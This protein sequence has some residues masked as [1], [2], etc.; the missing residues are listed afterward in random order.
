MEL[1]VGSKRANPDE[2]TL[3][4]DSGA[5]AQLTPLQL[6]G[7]RGSADSRQRLVKR[8]IQSARDPKSTA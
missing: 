6:Q 8:Q 3:V 5:R 1:Q 2:L 4:S 7:R